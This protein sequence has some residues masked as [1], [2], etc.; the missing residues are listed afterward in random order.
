MFGRFMYNICGLRLNGC[1]LYRL[2]GVLYLISHTPVPPRKL[3]GGVQACRGMERK[4]TIPVPLAGSIV[5]FSRVLFSILCQ[6]SH[7]TFLENP[8]GSLSD[9]FR[10]VSSDGSAI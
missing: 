10:G 4:F 5:R 6:D 2:V 8:P 1:V 7:P 9:Y 3:A